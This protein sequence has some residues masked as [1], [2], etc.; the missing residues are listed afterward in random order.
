MRHDLVLE[1]QVARDLLVELHGRHTADKTP[2]HG[3]SRLS[4]TPHRDRAEP[5]TV[6]H[7]RAWL[8]TSL[9]DCRMIP[10]PGVAGSIP[11]G[12]TTTFLQMGTF[13]FSRSGHF[14]PNRQNCRQIADG[15]RRHNRVRET[16]EQHGWRVRSVWEATTSGLPRER[17]LLSAVATLSGRRG[18]QYVL[19]IGAKDWRP[20]ARA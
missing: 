6:Q 7:N 13:P 2:H 5:W 8:T 9:H 17:A 20:C 1:Q 10:K 14:L 16:T 12:G 3:P 4:T 11:A 18:V 15:N 19:G